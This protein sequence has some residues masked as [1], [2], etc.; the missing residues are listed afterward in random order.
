MAELYDASDEMTTEFYPLIMIVDEGF[1][2]IEHLEKKGR[3]IEEAA[4]VH[5]ELNAHVNRVEDINGKVLW[6][7]T[8]Q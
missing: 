6:E 1:Y 8:K 2:P 5:G 3:T 4:K 7:R